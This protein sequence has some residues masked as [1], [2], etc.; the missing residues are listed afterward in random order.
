MII[1]LQI[2]QKQAP[3]HIGRIYAV[4]TKSLLF[5]LLFKLNSSFAVSVLIYSLLG[6][7]VSCA[8]EALQVPTHMSECGKGG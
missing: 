3:L 8:A 6:V 2:P 4:W 7:C 1:L 5:G